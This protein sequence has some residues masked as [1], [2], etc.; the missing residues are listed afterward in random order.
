[1]TRLYT[2][3]WVDASWSSFLLHFLGW[4]SRASHGNL[5]KQGE[6]M[7]TLQR[8]AHS[9]FI[10]PGPC[11]CEVCM[12]FSQQCEKDLYNFGN[13]RNVKHSPHQPRSEP[14]QLNKTPKGAAAFPLCL[15]QTSRPIAHCFK[16]PGD[17]QKSGQCFWHI[18]SCQLFHTQAKR[19]AT[20][21]N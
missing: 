14:F 13:E 4:K 7:Q 5:L 1:M 8:K 2:P 18:C 10:E 12:L 3:L 15:M 9:S 17:T 19:L 21:A 16:R 20:L 11:S 6:K